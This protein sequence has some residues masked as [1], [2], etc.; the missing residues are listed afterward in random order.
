MTSLLLLLLSATPVDVTVSGCLL[1]EN[2]VRAL[3]ELELHRGPG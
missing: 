1:D 3:A 2:K